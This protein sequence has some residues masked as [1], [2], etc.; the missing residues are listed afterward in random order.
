MS[1][2]VL[3]LDESGDHD[4]KR[5]DPNFP[6]FCLA[7]CAFEREYYKNV[8][9]ERIDMLKIKFWGH[10][11][12][13]FHSREIRK[14][15]GDF[16]ILMDPE[17]RTA[18]YSEIN[19]LMDEL[20]FTLFSVVIDKGKHLKKYKDRAEHPYNFAFEMLMERYSMYLFKKG[21]SNGYVLAESRGRNEDDLLEE[22]YEY[23]YDLGNYY[24]GNY[25]N[26]T[27]LGF[28]KKVENINGLQL[29]DLVAYPIARKVMAPDQK[30]L[31]FDVLKDKFHSN[32]RRKIGCGLKIFPDQRGFERI[33]K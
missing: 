11:D 19:A 20:D 13:I 16:Y 27:S 23:L 4:L 9:R 14:R 26:V 30:N 24:S 6:F 25:K 5:V 33:F 17:I 8:A 29:A 22:V 18:F 2:F 15:E 12:V 1:E 3:F 7:G 31:A 21:G 32:G 28:K 10:T